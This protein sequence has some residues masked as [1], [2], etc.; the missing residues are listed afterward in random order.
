[1][2]PWENA[3][4]NL[5]DEIKRTENKARGNTIRKRIDAIQRERWDHSS[6]FVTG[7]PK[8]VVHLHP[9]D[10]S[11]LIAALP[12]F[13]LKHG[14]RKGVTGFLTDFGEVGIVRD[15]DVPRGEIGTSFVRKCPTCKQERK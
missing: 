9:D 6:P 13:A 3:T 4:R 15:E 1:M 14:E 2:H 7:L 12:T 10:R 5:F 8:L 11:N